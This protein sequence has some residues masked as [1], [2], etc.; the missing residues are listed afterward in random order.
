MFLRSLIASALLITTLSS[1]AQDEKHLYKK[2]D[3]LLSGA[4]IVD[5]QEAIRVLD[6]ELAKENTKAA[7]WMRH[8]KARMQT[9]RTELAFQAINKAL[10]LEPENTQAML[11]K[12]RMLVGESKDLEGA[13]QLLDQAV[14][15][16]PASELYFYRGICQ[17]LIGDRQKALQDYLKAAE[18]GSKDPELL[19]SIAG[20]YA[21]QGD[22]DNSQRY[23]RQ[24]L[25]QAP[26]HYKAQDLLITS[27]LYKL[28]FEQACVDYDKAKEQLG[29]AYSNR[30][31]SYFCSQSEARQYAYIA[32]QLALVHGR[33]FAKAVLCYTK[34]MELSKPSFLYLLNRG[35]AYFCLADYKKAEADYLSAEKTNTGSK[36]GLAQLYANL[37][38][39]YLTIDK[40][41]KALF[42]SEKQLVLEPKSPAA[43]VNQGEAL[44]RLNKEAQAFNAANQA[45]LRNSQ[46]FRAYTLRSVTNLALGNKAA[47][48]ADAAAALKLEPGYAK[49][50]I[51]Q[52]DAKL[53]L[54]KEDFCID[55]AKAEELGAKEAIKRQAT[56]CK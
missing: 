41:K 16:E 5:G 42:W 45:L 36:K 47:A 43:L 46:S 26:T 56:H 8:A 25:D 54:G 20:I 6:T 37:V 44:L 35:Y 40:P 53:A 55:Y 1:S 12:A 50:W 52:G 19:S 10:E 31:F 14:S 18:F 4:S 27:Q 38:H 39:L 11:Q 17:Y 2:V 24:T 7:Y 23:A 51:A 13:I 49:A 34:A 15:I 28:E 22:F 48:Y 30:T 32:E 3:S 9:F 29:S 33:D 21:Q